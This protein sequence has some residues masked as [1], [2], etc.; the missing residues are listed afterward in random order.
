[1][2]LIVQVRMS[3]LLQRMFSELTNAIAKCCRIARRELLDVKKN[4]DAF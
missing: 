1:M 4:I 2:L 3:S